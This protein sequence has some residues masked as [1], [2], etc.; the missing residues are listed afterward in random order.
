MLPS[1]VRAQIE[2]DLPNGM[3]ILKHNGYGLYL[4]F[5]DS[6]GDETM[7]TL[8]ETGEIVTRE[9]EN[10]YGN[11]SGTNLTPEVIMFMWRLSRM[12]QDK[13]W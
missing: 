2:N 7:F 11:K 13:P 1:E 6:Y 5:T 9:C 10:S 3:E 8:G 12:A 4:K